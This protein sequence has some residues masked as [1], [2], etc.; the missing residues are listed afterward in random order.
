MTQ[1]TEITE[2]MHK[3]A[4]AWEHFKG[5]YDKRL[6][7]VEKKGTADPLTQAQL[8]RVHDSLSHYEQR[9]ASMEACV[10]RPKMG[11]VKQADSEHTAALCNYLRSGHAQSLPQ[12]EHKTLSAGIEQDGGYLLSQPMQHFVLQNLEALSPLRKLAAVETISSDT[13]ELIEAENG[14]AGAGWTTET[15]PITETGMPKLSKRQIRVHEV[16]AQ[17][18]ATQKLLDDSA[19]N[20]EAWIQHKVVESFAALEN[21][22]FINGDGV[23]KPRGILSYG[24]EIEQLNSSKEGVL[25][26]EDI[27]CLYYSLADQF[28]A[29]AS[30]MLNRTTLQQVRLLKDPSSGQFLWQPA[31]S[32]G[33]PSTLLGIPVVQSDYMPAYTSKGCQIAIA[34]FKAAYQIVDRLGVRIMRDPF[35]EKPF[36]KFYATKRVGADVKC[37]N[38]IKLL[39]I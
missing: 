27:I 38:A 20:V 8:E 15:G 9:L 25:C 23:G 31:Y 32:S 29:K 18:K 6:R 11:E 35:T 36:V 3:M 12:M 21:N 28:T 16:Y 13:L 19:V 1:A 17:P 4:H 7:E 30:F 26:A 2:Q 33:Q 5:V 37:F 10:S 24:K 39:K 14:L 22:A 34:D